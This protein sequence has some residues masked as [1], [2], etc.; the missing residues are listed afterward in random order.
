MTSTIGIPIKL[1]NEAQG[2][3]ITLEITSGQVYRGKLL[4]AED[5]M[6]IQLKDITVTARDG[7]VSHLD[8]VYIRGSHVRF[9]IVPDMLRAEVL[10]WLEEELRSAGRERADGVVH[11]EVD[12]SRGEIMKD[13]RILAV[14]PPNDGLAS[15]IKG[16]TNA[17]PS[18]TEGSIA[19]TTHNLNIVTPYYKA[20][21]PIWLDEVTDPKVWAS[22]FLKPEAREVITVLGAFIVCFSKPID[23]AGLEAIQ[24]LLENVAEVAKKGC[25]ASWDGVCLAVG[26]PQS[27]TPYLEKSFDEW[28]ELCQK[29]GFEYIDFASKGRNEFSEP[30]GLGRLKEAL[31]S[32]DWEGDD[33]SGE[34]DLED[35]D[36]ED[37]EAEGSK[38]F[39]IDAEEMEM[40]MAGMKRAIYGGG[41][42]L[43]EDENDDDQ[44]DE[45]EKL[46]TMMLKMQAVDMG[47]DLPESERKKLAAKAVGEIMKTL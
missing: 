37:D 6:N 17:I 38:G 20:E 25:G 21:V 33:E 43:E 13:I 22:E 27:I 45:V 30:T 4:E 3:V 5:N 26:M 29:S 46:Q 28:E 41:L 7:R 9:F 40:E 35:F 42:D 44:D 19:G 16:L 12:I 11:R 1:L 15:L 31:E 23:N 24:A 36:E 18:K 14:S 47:A 8:Q 39:G 34:V 32:N 2:H 10:G